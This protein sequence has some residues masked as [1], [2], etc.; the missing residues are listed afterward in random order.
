MT[1]HDKRFGANRAKRNSYRI[2]LD[3]AQTITLWP[4][5]RKPRIGSVADDW[6]AVGDDIRKAMRGE[7]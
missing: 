1:F 7:A 4:T 2:M 5:I 3:G 6:K